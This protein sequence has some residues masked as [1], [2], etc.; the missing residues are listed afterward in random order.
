MYGEKCSA[1]F[2]LKDKLSGE[3]LFTM[4][5]DVNRPVTPT[6][7]YEMEEI[8]FRGILPLQMMADK[9]TVLSTD[10]VFRRIKDV[11]DVYYLSKIF[12]FNSA[13]VLEAINNSGRSL[14]DFQGFLY[15]I[16]ELKHSYEKFRFSG[17]VK[18]PHFDE[19]YHNVKE[20]IEDVLPKQIKI[21]RGRTR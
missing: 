18:K 5:I 10:K 13:N 15:R 6:K 12:A 19:V 1:G 16:E 20:Y 17:D 7:I 8:R 4:D 21:R 9:L 2:E 14:G 11:I 3:T